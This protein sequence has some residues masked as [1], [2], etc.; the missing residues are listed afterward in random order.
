MLSV[1]VASSDFL[2]CL[3]GARCEIARCQSVRRVDS[4]WG[5]LAHFGPKRKTTQTLKNSKMANKF[6]C[7]FSVREGFLHSAS[8][9]LMLR[10]QLQRGSERQVK[11]VNRY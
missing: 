9:M 1:A 3:L 10:S 6:I 2:P 5:Q 11:N 8:C 7:V 4:C